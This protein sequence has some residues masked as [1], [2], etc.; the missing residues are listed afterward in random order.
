VELDNCGS[1]QPRK[2]R[3]TTVFL[4]SSVPI[5]SYLRLGTRLGSELDRALP[6]NRRAVGSIPASASEAP[7]N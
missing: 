5:F 6:Q 3:H 4:Y 1:E 7:G 2:N